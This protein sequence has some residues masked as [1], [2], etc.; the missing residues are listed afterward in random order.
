MSRS[1]TLDC[2][3]DDVAAFLPG[4]PIDPHCPSALPR[5]EDHPGQLLGKILRF[6]LSDLESSESL[7]WLKGG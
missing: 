6:D 5:G 3:L 4:E 2:S 7:G 1:A